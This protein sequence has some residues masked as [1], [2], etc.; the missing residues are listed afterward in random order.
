[1]IRPVSKP[2]TPV[3]V[4]DFQVF[5]GACENTMKAFGKPVAAAHEADLMIRDDKQNLQ[6]GVS[7]LYAIHQRS[8]NRIIKIVE[9]TG[10]AKV[11]TLPVRKAAK[12]LIPVVKAA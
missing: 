9:A 7:A 10:Q 8:E 5:K 1:M 12:R 11:I 6:A 3:F 2:R 4:N